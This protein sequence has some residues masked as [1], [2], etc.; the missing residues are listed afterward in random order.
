M[1]HG[2]RDSLGFTNIVYHVTRV[3]SS[4]Y[5]CT[6]NRERRA[7]GNKKEHRHKAWR[8]R[9]QLLSDNPDRRPRVEGREEDPYKK[10]VYRNQ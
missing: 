2:L 9:I 6:Q 5:F 10:T 8:Q 4:G 7:H 1:N 3:F